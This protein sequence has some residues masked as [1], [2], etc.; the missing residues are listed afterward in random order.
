LCRTSLVVCLVLVSAFASAI[1][2]EDVLAKHARS[3]GAGL[4][5]VDSLRVRLRVEEP[6][7]TVEG[8]YAADRRGRVR[9]DIFLEGRRVFSEGVDERGAWS[10]DEKGPPQEASP[11]GLAAL[12]HGRLFNLYGLEELPRSGHVLVLEKDSTRNGRVYH[13]VRIEL[14]DRFRTWRWIDAETGRL[15]I[16][17]DFRALHPDLDP[18]PVW[19]ETEQSDFRLVGGAEFPYASRQVE[20]ETGRLLQ[21][22]RILDVEPNPCLSEEELRRPD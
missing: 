7:F 16:K 10:M 11:D 2:L 18:R 22:T 9:V 4:E 1:S 13:V 5:T 21:T 19:I 8:S 14:S 12:E 20:V 3:R 17:R 15:T 6:E